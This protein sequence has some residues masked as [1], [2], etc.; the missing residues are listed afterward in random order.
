[1]QYTLRLAH[2]ADLAA[3]YAVSQA[4]HSSAY[5]DQL[6]PADFR[7][8]YDER[9]RKTAAH[10]QAFV[11]TMSHYVA[12]SEWEVWVAT[13]ERDVIAGYT[14]WHQSSPVKRLLKGLFVH[15]D[16]QGN[17]V[18]KA[19]FERSLQSAPAGCL[20]EL[21]VIAANTV[22][23]SLYQKHGF[24]VRGPA[25]KLFYGAPQEVMYRQMY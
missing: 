16:A 11:D 10:Q 21:T 1:M 2:T 9:Y 15:P 22:A 20:I 17:G 18:G 23:K 4:A 5:Y 19:L 14:L 6:I 7:Q 3:M 12:D 25:E 13:D 24:V 8:E